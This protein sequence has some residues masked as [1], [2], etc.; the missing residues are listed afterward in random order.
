MLKI[1]ICPALGIF[2]NIADKGSY[3]VVR[4]SYL[5][6]LNELFRLSKRDK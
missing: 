2:I 1:A 4:T 6:C 5:S 3:Y